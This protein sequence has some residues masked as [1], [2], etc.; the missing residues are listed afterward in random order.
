MNI[1]HIEDSPL[2]HVLFERALK[3]QAIQAHTLR[4]ST[5]EE[6]EQALQT[7]A[8]DLI[9][10]DYQLGDI[11][12]LDVWDKV[13]RLET[14]PPF[15]L[16][17]GAIGETAVAEALR[18]GMSDFVHKNNLQSLGLA[19]QRVMRL[20]ALQSEK[21][22]A[23]SQLQRSQEQI[24]N[25]VQH[26]QKVTEDERMAFARDLHDEIGGTLTAVKLEIAWLQLH[27]QDSAH[28]QHLH[29]AN[30]L[31]QSATQSCQRMMRELRPPVLDGGLGGAIEWLAGNHQQ[32]T[33]QTVQLVA[34]QLP[35][36]IDERISLTV[37]RTVQEAL[38]NVSKYASHGSVA[39][40][41]DGAGNAITVEIADQGP[42]IDEQD[43]SKTG[44][45]GLRGL[46]ERANSVG[47]WL[48]IGRNRHGGCTLTLTIPLSED[49][50]HD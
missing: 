7:Q 14:P 28:Q 34:R 8:I 35:A 3:A 29:S 30:S 42:G 13:R 33:R 15:I 44:S 50:H 19:I 48:D 49:E 40:Q 38:T 11:N 37:Y 1:L 4:A 2:D 23:E 9:A 20:H 46:R 31:L 39:I 36:S 45:F 25:L 27:A 47:G 18:Q 12:A 21:S 6:V 22:R 41:L 32:R 26:L 5:L 10:S 43:L 17:S 24:A 16:I